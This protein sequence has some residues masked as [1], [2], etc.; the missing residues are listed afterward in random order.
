MTETPSPSIEERLAALEVLAA[1][2]VILGPGETLIIRA[3][4]LT[5]SQMHE[6]QRILDDWHRSGDLPFRA[7]VVIGDE[8]A[9]AKAKPDPPS[10]MDDVRED[11]FRSGSVEAV[12]LTHLPTG[13]AAE[14]S[15]RDEAVARLSRALLQRG[16][17]SVNAARR[18]HGLPPFDGDF[19]ERSL[20]V[21]DPG[22]VEIA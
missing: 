8:L 22:P 17:I 4:D 2:P 21:R 6:Y 5:P 15:S 20:N 14:G 9:A 1:V 7:I 3:N 11:V 13:V 10:F 16:D 12:R 18:A 19:A